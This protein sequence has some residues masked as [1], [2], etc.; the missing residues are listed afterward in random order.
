MNC[1]EELKTLAAAYCLTNKQIAAMTGYAI[2]TVK[3]W[4]SPPLSDS[5][6][7]KYR[8]MPERAMKL[9]KYEIADRNLKRNT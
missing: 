7:K 5:K 2:S 3:A 1:N 4:Q 9:L 8:K 6:S